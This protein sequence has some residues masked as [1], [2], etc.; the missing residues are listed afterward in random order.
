MQCSLAHK[1]RSHKQNRCSASNSVGLIFT[2]S[3]WSAL[4]IT[5]PTPTPSLEKT[6]LYFGKFVRSHVSMT[7]QRI[8][9]TIRIFLKFDIGKLICGGGILALDHL[10]VVLLLVVGSR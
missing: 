6:S 4:L 10:G 8:A 9:M 5:T 7:L 3:Y 2:R 1:R